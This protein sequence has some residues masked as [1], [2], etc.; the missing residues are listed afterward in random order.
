MNIYSVPG[1][2]WRNIIRITGNIAES[3]L[4]Y[5]RILNNF[6]QKN[7]EINLHGEAEF[8]LSFNTIQT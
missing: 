8:S 4:F 7:K 3:K 5:Y 2:G 6:I 1:S